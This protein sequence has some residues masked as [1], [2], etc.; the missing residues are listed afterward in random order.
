VSRGIIGISFL[1]AFLAGAG[2]LAAGI[3]AAGVLAFVTLLLG[4]VQPGPTVLF[5]PTGSLPMSGLGQ[6]WT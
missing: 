5:I 4:V 1:Q 2:F 3:P 6:K